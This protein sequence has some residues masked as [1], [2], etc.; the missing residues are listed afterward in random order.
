MEAN[1]NNETKEESVNPLLVQDLDVSLIS[2]DQQTTDNT[3]G[4][5][6]KPWQFKKGQSGNPDGRPKGS[7]N[8]KTI[9]D[10]AL[11]RLA[12]DNGV[13]PD[14]IH[15]DIV[16]NGIVMAR[17]GSFKFYKDL[18]D[19]LYGKPKE[20]IDHTTKGEKINAGVARFVII[21]GSIP[22]EE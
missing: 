7:E 14:S 19:R 1:F 15:E 4:K 3:V 5:Q 2:E 10:R 13:D 17:G 9:F 12:K 21:D 16:L 20:S 8:F 22:E 6:S 18:F 11:K